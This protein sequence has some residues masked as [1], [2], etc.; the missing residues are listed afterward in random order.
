MKFRWILAAALVAGASYLAGCTQPTPSHPSGKAKL[1]ADANASVAGFK[2]EDP[3]LQGM[4][5]Q[6]VGYAVFP[7]VG[8][9]G[10]IAGASYGKGEVFEGGEKIGYADITQA[11][12]GLQAGAQT[13]DELIIFLRP[14]DFKDF[15]DK[16]WALAANLS[17]VFIKPGAA[18]TSDTSK[19]VVV[20]VRTKGG[21]M[22]EA[23]VGGQRFRFTSL[24]QAATQPS[25]PQ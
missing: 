12:F 10:F 19:G 21:L 18:A 16:E 25:E 11:T 23:A 7:D 22:G 17:G 6:A 2:A 3:S 15:K 9:A 14:Q 20:F 4:L 24:A 13:F 5:N 8:K 1:E